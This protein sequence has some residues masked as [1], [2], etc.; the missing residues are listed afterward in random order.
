MVKDAERLSQDHIPF[1]Q[2]RKSLDPE[3]GPVNSES[4][5]SGWVKERCCGISDIFRSAGPTAQCFWLHQVE[6][7]FTVS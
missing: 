7:L 2:S 4:V 5:L 1:D 3:C 6:N